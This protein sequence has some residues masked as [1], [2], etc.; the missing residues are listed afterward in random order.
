[1]PREQA[2]AHAGGHTGAYGG[3]ARRSGAVAPRVHTGWP[4]VQP[5]ADIPRAQAGAAGGLRRGE[6]N[7]GGNTGMEESG[8]GDVGAAAGG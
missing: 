4:L 1:M 3:R 2:S 5:L 8:R 7:D 6:A